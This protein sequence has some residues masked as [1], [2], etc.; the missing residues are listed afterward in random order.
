MK[1]LSQE[2]LN[3]KELRPLMTR[4]GANAALLVSG[5]D[6][7]HTAHIAAALRQ[8]T[9][10]PVVVVAPDET[11]AGRFRSDIDA[12][13]GE[14]TYFLASREFTFHDAEIISRD[15]E[16]E[17]IRTLYAAQTGEA[18]V[19]VATP[20][21]L[22]QRTMN[23]VPAQS[24]SLGENIKPDDLLKRLAEL[25]YARSE[26]VEGI[27]Q[28]ARRGGIIDI[29][30]P[31][32]S[33]P[34]RIEFL[35]NEIDRIGVFDPETQ[36]VIENYKSAVILPCAETLPGLTENFADALQEL[37]GKIARRN[38][39]GEL[40]ERV[41]ADYNRVCDGLKLET[42]D[43]YMGLIYGDK[44][45]LGIDYIPDNAIVI[46][47]EPNR[48]AER[49]KNYLWRMNEDISALL[50]GG[51]LCGD[52][53]R[54]NGEWDACI[55]DFIK[56][57]RTVLMVDTFRGG[58]YPLNPRITLTLTAKH[59]PGYGGSLPTAL[60]DIRRY[61]DDKF[62]VVV[63]CGDEQ[64][65]RAM[66][67]LLS[68]S[69][70]PA[71]IDFKLSQLP[72]KGHCAITLSGLSAG[73]E[74]PAMSM[75][76]IT[77]GQV[78]RNAGSVDAQLSR[79]AK[80]RRSGVSA[81]NKKSLTSYTDLSVGDL[82]VHEVH[83]IGRFLGMK[84]LDVDGARKEY[85]QIA[86]RGTDR[87]YVPATQLDMVSKYIGGGGGDNE[88]VRLSKLGGTDWVKA[89]AR[90][91]AAAKDLADGLIKLYSERLQRPGHPFA[92]DSGWQREFE[93]A[94]P[95]NE[96]DDQIKAVDEIKRDM[97]KSIPMDRLL[98]G[99]VGFGK[100]EVALRAV[101][102]CIADN[103]QAAI[104]VP[105]TVLA[106]QHYITA[107]QRFAKFPVTIE[108][109][110]RFQTSGQ[111]SKS[112]KA[113]KSG[114]AD[115]VIGTHR[116]LSKDI[117]FKNLGL[118]IVDEEQRFGVS[119]KEK[120]KQL[121][122]QIDVLSMSATPIPRTLNMALAGLRDMS[123]IEEPPAGRFP[124]QTYVL[125]HD[126]SVLSDAIR[127]E[128]GRG[129]QVYYLHNR[130]ETIDRTAAK[131]REM[132][133]TNAGDIRIA[134]AHGG[135]GEE[136]LS[137]VMERVSSGDV[138]I[139]VCTTIIEAGIDIPNVN[140][141]VIED[142]DRLGLAQLHQ[143]RGRVG[144]STRHAFAYFTYRTGKVLSEIA[145][146]RLS[147]IRE[148]AAFN[149]GVKIALRDLEIRGAGNLLGAEQ[150]GHMTGVGFDM[151]LKLLEEAVLEEKGEPI[152]RKPTCSADLSV[153]A[154][155]PEKY[156]PSA[157][158]RMDIYRRIA[159]IDDKEEADD[160]EDELT[161]RYGEP[162]DGVRELIQ[163][164]LLR[165]EA[166]AIGVS[167]VSQKGGSLLFKF[168]ELD[169][170]KITVLLAD[171]TLAKRIKIERNANAPLVS[172]KLQ[173]GKNVIEEA[174]TFVRM[175][176]E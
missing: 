129:G 16:H 50:E 30:S 168:T 37:Y 71:F 77:E 143:I 70:I 163:V 145:Q 54:F 130:I 144:R 2:L 9:E 131:L 92:S 111:I 113:I 84:Q 107:S 98:C 86:Y 112:L 126:W 142:A 60:D 170:A 110:S 45:T 57:S 88:Q 90:A 148:F 103:R 150:S 63:L 141:L 114:G 10:R 59:L 66:Y 106:R 52:I 67:D 65:A 162:P 171:R 120:L 24:V 146:K 26:Q 172:M 74:Y 21:G 25:G 125:E 31:A 128:V 151:Y 122:K 109:L 47:R 11:E 119:H 46:L 173:S 134:V 175:L 81:K 5:A 49:A 96:T 8:I 85:I 167:D 22:L 137:D 62:R 127:R 12:I 28:F 35:G 19:I 36:R 166:A 118:L 164:A 51:I 33:L 104:L 43:R 95:Y 76:V 68:D 72:E 121:T 17:R 140:T 165:G 83:G 160:M 13:T 161:D 4:L 14:D 15:G 41:T 34:M 100:T 108:V 69:D 53:A 40:K 44:I 1:L 154:N 101:M 139:L 124:V 55:G 97:E 116:M 152:K 115:I 93:D 123:S 20:D 61:T 42:A 176:G 75:A 23:E 91:K 156:I 117:E 105:T 132:L 149:S 174:L 3:G 158:Q 79:A 87:V 38:N 138:Q 32:G 18:G 169:G 58:T 133:E 99:D 7:V 147:T 159:L 153:S 82:V 29:F 27:G 64:K 135:M 39:T 102:K 157:E 78:F 56:A 89:K 48:L 155:I 80:R 136:E 94:F 6:G 73:M